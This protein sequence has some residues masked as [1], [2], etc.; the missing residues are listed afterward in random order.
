MEHRQWHGSL[1]YI[2][3]LESFKTF[4]SVWMA[5]SLKSFPHK[6]YLKQKLSKAI[7]QRK[8]F[9]KVFSHARGEKC[10]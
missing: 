5:L 3:T 8:S 1:L 7:S 2:R 10:W 4:S 6:V 9:I